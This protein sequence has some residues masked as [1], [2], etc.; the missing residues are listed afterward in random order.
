MRSTL[1]IAIFI[2]ISH[3]PVSNSLFP[4]NMRYLYNSNMGD[5]ECYSERSGKQL[6]III[7][8]PDVDYT[9]QLLEKPDGLYLTAV[10]TSA[11]FSSNT[12]TYNEPVMRYPD[13]LEVGYEWT[14]EGYEIVDDE[15]NGMTLRSRIEALESITTEAG[16]FECYKISSSFKAEDG[17]HQQITEWIKPGIGIIKFHAHIEST[18]FIGFLQ[19]LLGYSEV[20]FT[21]KSTEG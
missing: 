20:E 21:L 4:E 13:M 15:R 14:F 10:E 5:S 12:T 18:G 17:S 11:L 9:Q 8:S 3:Y 2:V 1:L 19:D 6:S 16:T 7:I